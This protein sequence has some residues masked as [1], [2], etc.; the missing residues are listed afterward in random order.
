MGS[1]NAKKSQSGWLPR[2]RLH[3]NRGKWINQG[4]FFTDRFDFITL[5]PTLIPAI[6]PP[7]FAE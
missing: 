2:L 7:L 5:N 6:P 4:Q 1:V 3:V